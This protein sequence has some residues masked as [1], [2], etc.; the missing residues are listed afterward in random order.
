MRK[1]A[2][3]AKVKTDTVD[4]L[5]SEFMSNAQSDF[6]E[7]R[8][9]PLL[10]A[11]VHFCSRNLPLFLLCQTGSRGHGS[12][13]EP[14]PAPNPQ[15]VSRQVCSSERARAFCE[16]LVRTFFAASQK[17]NL[18]NHTARWVASNGSDFA[19]TLLQ[20]DGR[21]FGF[22]AKGEN[23]LPAA[24]Y[25]NRKCKRLCLCVTRCMIRC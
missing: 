18:I 2:S 25:R 12:K 24:Y 8:P 4:G 16:W 3:E 9:M 6:A 21:K 22:L 7:V 13:L 20:S 1:P 10:L 5:L 19:A 17:A 11:G 23:T 14:P 15:L